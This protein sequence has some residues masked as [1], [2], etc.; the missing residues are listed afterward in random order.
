[1]PKMP[2]SKKSTSYRPS[3]VADAAT[4]PPDL[5]ELATLESGIGAEVRRL[6]KSH[7]LTVTELAAAAGI[8]AGTLSKIENGATASVT[9]LHALAKALNVPLGQ[10]FVEPEEQRD[11]SFVKGG[12][13]VRIAR[14]GTKSG[15]LYQLLGHSLSGDIGVDPYLITLRKDAVPYTGF[16]YSGL[17]FIYMLSGK[18]LFRHAD[19]TYELEPTDT[20]LFDATARHGPEELLETPI[21]YLSVNIYYRV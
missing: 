17:R 7:E 15:H 11:C 19:R 5:N 6:R 13:G 12:T 18:V 8:S 21:R 4:R 3:A 20:L 16:R 10:L 14:R 2:I 9:K 1:M